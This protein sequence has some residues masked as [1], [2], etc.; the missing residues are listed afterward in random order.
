[1]TQTQTIRNTTAML[2]ELHRSLLNSHST[3]EFSDGEDAATSPY[4]YN[5]SCAPQSCVCETDC[6]C[7]S[8]TENE[9]EEE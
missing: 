1:M 4:V 5:H 8:E 2:A 7:Q 3:T 9:S 6:N